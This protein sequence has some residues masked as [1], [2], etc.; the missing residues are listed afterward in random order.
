MGKT[1]K[2]EEIIILLKEI[3]PN[4]EI[5]G[6]YKKEVGKIKKHMCRYIQCKCKIDSHEW[7]C[8][9][10]NLLRGHG[11]TKCGRKS[12][13]SKL[14]FTL[15]EITEKLRTINPNIEILSDKYINTNKK[16]K[17]K[18]LVDGWEWYASWDSLSHRIGCPK[19]G[20]KSMADN[21]KL[22]IEEIKSRL[23][24]I[25][26]NIKIL[27]DYYIDCKEKL[28]C[29]CKICKNEWSVS[30]ND[31][32]N[33]KGCP[34]CGLKRRSG[35]N[36]WNWKGGITPLQNYLRLRLTQWKKDS[37]KKYDY[38][39]DITG[40]N[41]KKLQIHHPLNFSDIL[42]ETLEYLNLPIYPQVNLYTDVE[43]KDIE[44]MCSK[45]H[46]KY[47]LGIC[48]CKEEHNLFHTTYGN[49]NNTK[50]QYLKFKEMR[51]EQ[52]RNQVN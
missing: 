19:C 15:E 24:I 7:D 21:N 8:A 36:N 46:A 37:L 38:K 23:N 4:I 30:W 25:N 3:S 32:A 20:Y 44:D 47:G 10:G 49:K 39:C 28:L 18:C 33:K 16:L 31:L 48:L 26:S 13:S 6:E 9:L 35:N 1:K 29:R 2:L 42:L 34:E 11:C 50:E 40:K 43:L 17:L 22:T 51:L 14:V 12:V 52:I 45:I 5:L 41:S 27:D